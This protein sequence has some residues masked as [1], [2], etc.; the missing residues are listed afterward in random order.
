MNQ[1]TELLYYVKQ[2]AEADTLV[3]TVTKGDFNLLDLDKA[4][5]FPLVHNRVL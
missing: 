3:N 4:N 5:I 1:Y 2:L